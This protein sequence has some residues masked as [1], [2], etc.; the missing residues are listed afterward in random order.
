MYST[1][2]FDNAPNQVQEGSWVYYPKEISNIQD[3]P[4][5]VDWRKRG[6]TSAVKNQGICGS[7]WAFATGNAKDD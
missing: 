5:S 1:S 6:A 3:L 2:L 7:C 4:E